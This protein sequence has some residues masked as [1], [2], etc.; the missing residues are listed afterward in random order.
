MPTPP[1]PGAGLAT[2]PA[3]AAPP[4]HWPGVLLILLAFVAGYSA[5]VLIGRAEEAREAR[6]LGV[7]DPI[8]LWLRSSGAD[9]SDW[10]ERRPLLAGAGLSAAILPI[11]A[12]LLARGRAGAPAALAW[13]AV[14]AVA[15]AQILL[16]RDA[17]LAGGLLY[18][19][20]V[21]LAFL[22]G[23]WRPL[24]ALPGFP[25]YPPDAPA[26]PAGGAWRPSWRVEC[27]AVL[28]LL[29]GTLIA[30]TWALTEQSDFLDLE[31]VDSFLQS[32][33]W[34]GIQDYLRHTFLA[35]NPGAAHQPLQYVVFK[36]FGTSIFTLRMAAVLWS[37]AGVLL[38]YLLVRRLAGPAPAL[39]SAT[40]MSLAADQLFWARS[41]NGYFSPVPVLA[42]GTVLVGLWMVQRFSPWAVALAA[43]LMPLSRTVYTTC[44]AM[45]AYPIGLTL[46][47]A[48]CARGLWR[49]LWYVLPILAVGLL[50][51]VFWLS[52]MM[53]ALTGGEWRFVHPASIYG[54]SAWTKQGEFA[55]AGP[56]ELV[57]KQARSMAG[58]ME[59]VARDNVYRTT[60]GF[61]HWYMRAQ[62]EGHPTTMHVALVALCML[63]VGYLLA[64]LQDRRAFALLFWLVLALLP[65]VMSRDAAP[66]RM[67]MLFLV[68]QALSGITLAVV[69]R[70]TRQAGSRPAAALASVVLAVAVALIALTNAVS[71]YRMPLQPVIFGDYLRVLRPVFERSDAF[72]LNLPIAFRSHLVFG[73]MARFL[74][75]APGFQAVRA[76]EWLR[77]ALHP[78]ADFHDPVYRLFLT[79]AEIAAARAAHQ[80]RRVSF[81]FFVDPTTRAQVELVA[82][83]YPDAERLDYTSPRSERHIVALTIDVDDAAALRRPSVRLLAPDAAGLDVLAGVPLTRVEGAPDDGAALDV[84]GGIRLDADGWY[85]FGL[86]PPCPA[87]S[88]AVGGQPSGTGAPRPLAAGVHPFTLSLAEA[89]ACPLPL[90]LTVRTPETGGPAPLPAERFTAAAVTTV[91]AALA[92]PVIAYAGY[93]PARVLAQLPGRAIDL[94]HEPDGS[95]AV[96]LERHGTSRLL[97]LTA[98]GGAAGEW[99]LDGSPG[100]APSSLAVA[101][102]GVAAVLS[103][104]GVVLYDAGGRRLGAWTHPWL[105]FETEL[106]FLNPRLLLATI[107]HRNSVAVFRRDGE[108][109][110]ELSGFHGG[111]GALFAPIALALAA[112]GELA[113]VQDDGLAQLFHT[114]R[115]DFRPRFIRD[116]AAVAGRS[117]AFDGAERLWIAD[118]G[119]VRVYDAQGARMMAAVPARD[120]GQRRYGESARLLAGDDGMYIL[121]PEGSRLWSVS[122]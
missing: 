83:L 66:R 40:F 55:D 31:V 80:P 3:A 13:L 33:T 60:N 113:V 120:P 86:D 109:L 32:H 51:W 102:D 77:T 59:R 1:V 72:F 76:D 20:A 65:G 107:A 21:L 17:V 16:L 108:L 96:L 24:R 6:I 39:V 18:G 105:V 54:G 106:A 2:V 84:R 97:R 121:D 53:Q 10:L 70:A 29:A 38:M 34:H 67:M 117:A 49:R 8:F 7:F 35:T 64:Q 50:A 79:D 44:L 52:Y 9:G 71:H 23:L 63:G 104:P 25:P 15:W 103:A 62:I 27:G 114:P 87:A 69:L 43:L 5:L 22:L 11:L 81:V 73:D 90:R 91:A 19:A 48:V 98:Q 110:G 119:V 56:L 78:Q 93:A 88:L 36:L 89:A 26:L 45:V 75:Q 57:V 37:T 85:A 68:A 28:A 112:G 58:H 61:S 12:L 116:F 42:L 115:S 82:A 4:R 118:D 100:H 94:A 95:L 14:L 47:A 99:P 122:R 111:R 101:S 30:R 46:H 74:R 92:P 41:E